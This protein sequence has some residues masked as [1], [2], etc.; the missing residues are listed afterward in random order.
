MSQAT[1]TH[2][3]TPT[4]EQIDQLLDTIAD[5]FARQ[6][7]SPILHTPSEQNLVYEEVT[8]PALDG[9][10]LEGWFIP[11]DGSQKLIIANHPMDSAGREFL[12]TLSRGNQSGVPAAMRSR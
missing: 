8:F 11:A 1:L 2:T 5:S 10:P 9:V 3:P 6:L 4:R 12:L 7:R